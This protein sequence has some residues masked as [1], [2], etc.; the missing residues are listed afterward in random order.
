MT[1]S[2]RS[3]LAAASLLVRVPKFRI[4]V[5]DWDLG[6]AGKVESIAVA[7][8]LGFEGIQL[9]LD[10]EKGADRLVLANPELQAAYLEESKRLGLPL[11]GASLAGLQANPKQSGKSGESWVAAGIGITRKLNAGVLLVPFFFKDVPF[12]A[13]SDYVTALLGD[14]APDAEKAGVAIGL[15]NWLSAEDNVRIM[16]RIHSPAVRMYYDVGI[17]TRLGLDAP[18]EIR[19]LGKSRI[20]QI[21]LKDDVRYFGEGKVDFAAVLRAMAGIGYEGFAH[22]EKSGAVKSSTVEEDMRRNLNYIRAMMKQ[23]AVAA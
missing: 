22:I 21:H 11:A 13:T 6:R 4:G 14:L 16:D 8:R 23:A 17:T 19:W 7:K 5:T 9:R 1:I 2:R 3:F 18:K 10:R 12:A 20:A 15:E